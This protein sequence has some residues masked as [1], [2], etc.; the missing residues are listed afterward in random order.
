MGKR[1]RQKSRPDAADVA[2]VVKA[3]PMPERPEA[4]APTP[5]GDGLLLGGALLLALLAFVAAEGPARAPR[6]LSLVR[7]SAVAV[8]AAGV[9]GWVLRTRLREHLPVLAVLGGAG[10]L[11]GAMGI[12]PE[13]L[14]LP[15]HGVGDRLWGFPTLI[16][17]PMAGAALLSGRSVL[18]RTVAASG[19]ALV[20]VGLL[21]PQALVGDV[22]LAAL[23]HL[24]A[25]DSAGAYASV[26]VLLL[27]LLAIYAVF[28]SAHDPATRLPELLGGLLALALP[29]WEATRFA[30]GAP[31]LPGLLLASGATA[32]LVS[33][34]R[35]TLAAVPAWAARAL[36][37]AGEGL[38]V[39]GLVTLWLL[40]KSFT[41]RWSTTD[42]NIYFYDAVLVTQGKLPYR[43]FFFAHPPLHLLPAVVLFGLFG[44]HLRLAKLIPV[45]TALLTGL[46]LW[47]L[48]RQRIGKLAAF[49]TLGAF[50][51]AFELL[52][53]STNMNGVDLTALW[54]VA[55][56][57]ALLERRP[58][59][60]GALLG[61]AVTTGFYAIGAALALLVLA[62]F[63]DLR[64]GLRFLAGLAL[65]G[66]G[67]NVICWLV[68][69]EAFVE[70]VYR[71]HVEKA[72]K[73]KVAEFIQ[74]LYHHMPLF[75]GA[76]LA[77]VLLGLQQ[78][79]RI[80]MLGGGDL[81]EKRGTFFSPFKL[82]DEPGAGL[83]K[84]AF[85]VTLT[86]LVE[87]TRFQEIYDFYFILAFPTAA[88]C[89]GYTVAA[90][91]SAGV[92][93][94]RQLARGAATWATAGTAALGAVWALQVP[95]LQ[96]TSWIFSAPGREQPAVR[97]RRGKVLA[98]PSGELVPGKGANPEFLRRGQVARTYPWIEPP[99]WPSVAGPVVRALFW[100]DH[101]VH[102]DLEPDYRHF[103]WQKSLYFSIADEMGDAIRQGS[104][105]DETI[106]GNSLVAP[107]VALTSGRR[108]AADFVDTNGKRFKT[109]NTSLEAFFKAICADRIRYLV[110]APDGWFTNELLASL[111][112]VETYFTKGRSFEDPWNKFAK[113]G[114]APFTVTLWEL[115]TVPNDDG[116]RCRWLPP[117]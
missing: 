81:G 16:G 100:R 67:I 112:T 26:L 12:C 61:A 97:N 7:F 82:F 96:E 4:Q 103:L 59:V 105:E 18:A 109:G 91:L 110:A 60:G 95:F 17:A 116:P 70:S 93:D 14:A 31:A 44:F 36:P 39:A 86:F 40:M 51:F 34:L 35:P 92:H 32:L 54:V 24:A 38:A 106:A 15:T 47:R 107:A 72:E 48:C 102:F 13:L 49:V 104:A 88:I 75:A 37:Q 56:L 108:I 20:V 94:L 63:A 111:P 84:I 99:V 22:R 46:L 9:V 33:G 57:Y 71:F 52:Q 66:G 85:L 1:S 53:A 21:A 30:S 43:D 55:G 73:P 89:T 78:L 87:M 10:L 2:P 11:L 6:S 64:A 114:V 5:L 65:V 62:F 98:P 113:P 69:G 3:P 41:W 45:G 27:S 76:L 83:V 29:A 90:L 19:A 50:L 42:E 8:G 68:G 117:P 74:T 25:L 101:R 23:H 77:P 58:L 115:K 28:L 79:R 80:P